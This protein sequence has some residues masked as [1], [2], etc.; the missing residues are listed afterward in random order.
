MSESA[1]SGGSSQASASDRYGLLRRPTRMPEFEE[2]TPLSPSLA[3]TTRERVRPQTAG[4]VPRVPL[5]GPIV[6]GSAGRLRELSSQRPLSAGGSETAKARK[7]SG[8]DSDR[9]R[10]VDLSDVSGEPLD[11]QKSSFYTAVREYE[12]N[13]SSLRKERDELLDAIRPM[14]REL[15]DANSAVKALEAERRE[16]LAVRGLHTS[17]S[18]ALNET[19][20]KLSVAQRRV[21]SLE[22]Q[23]QD[24]EHEWRKENENI[25]ARAEAAEKRAVELAASLAQQERANHS[26]SEAA[27]S[28][29]KQH[30]AAHA[31]KVHALEEQLRHAAQNLK[32]AQDAERAAAK[33]ANEWRDHANAL[34]QQLKDVARQS[35][36]SAET[37]SAKL[38]QCN[39]ALNRAEGQ[40]IKERA[41]HAANAMKVEELARTRELKLQ[42]DA[43]A[44]VA[45]LKEQVGAL[46]AD[47]ERARKGEK[48]EAARAQ[49]L[50][51]DELA[52]LE[53]R[54]RGELQ[55]QKSELE[56]ERRQA[57]RK[58]EQVRRGGWGAGIRHRCMGVQ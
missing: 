46:Q 30:N 11:H 48:D 28:D 33:S 10:S 17:T 12:K 32:Q 34:E 27:A 19:I 5:G 1:R 16:L 45:A 25:A 51:K 23:L 2:V 41:E 42:R 35:T 22:Q 52:K 38:T 13:L 39:L 14:R 7:T 55:K 26:Q 9:S 24:G 49:L 54:H 50:L 21:R 20:E 6:G 58:V 53:M 4:R 18:S 43:D 56:E 40:L 31:K 36:E 15:D 57:L 44:R 8:A 37:L 3:S 29:L 47:L